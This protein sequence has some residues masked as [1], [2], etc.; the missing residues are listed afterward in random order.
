MQ[1]L[2]ILGI[3]NAILWVLEPYFNNFVQNLITRI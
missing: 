3:G 2:I 1:Q